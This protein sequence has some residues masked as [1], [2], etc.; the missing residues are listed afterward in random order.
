ME[1]D[2][3]S[4]VY[5]YRPLCLARGMET[6]AQIHGGQFGRKLTKN[7]ENISTLLKML[8]AWSFL[9]ALGACFS[10][11]AHVNN[12]FPDRHKCACKCKTFCTEIMER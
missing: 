3:K 8:Q 12:G 10:S 4:S 2:Y 7:P 6:S 1:C 11:R 9:W 5:V